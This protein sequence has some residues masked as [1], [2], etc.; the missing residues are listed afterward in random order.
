MFQSIVGG[1]SW[2]LTIVTTM[3]D[4]VW[5]QCG[6]ERAESNLEQLGRDVWKVRT[7]VVDFVQSF[8]S[9]LGCKFIPHLFLTRI[10]AVKVL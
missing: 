6:K 1:P 5:N 9:L 8:S 2:Q 7:T 10:T 4:R 3:W